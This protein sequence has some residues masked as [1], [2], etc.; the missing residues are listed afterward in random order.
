M[1]GGQPNIRVLAE[2]L[3]NALRTRWTPQPARESP[4]RSEGGGRAAEPPPSLPKPVSEPGYLMVLL[5]RL[6]TELVWPLLL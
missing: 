2:Q 4:A 3:N 5:A 1:E 6:D